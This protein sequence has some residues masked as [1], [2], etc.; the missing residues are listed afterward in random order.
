MS[1]VLRHCASDGRVAQLGERLVRNE[2]AVGS[3]PISST[4]I[5]PRNSLEIRPNKLWLIGIRLPLSGGLSGLVTDALLHYFFGI[6]GNR[7]SRDRRIP[8]GELPLGRTGL[9]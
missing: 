6:L 8:Q 1:K 2:E 3:I 5:L 9:P 7:N 4:N